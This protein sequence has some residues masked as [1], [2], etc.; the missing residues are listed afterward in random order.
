MNSSEQSITVSGLVANYIS[1][2]K[3]F[4]NLKGRARRSEFWYF[5]LVNLIIS[6]SLDFSIG[7]VLPSVAALISLI[8]NLAI[9][10]PS[11]ALFVRRMHDVEKSGWFTLVPVYNVILAITEGTH[12]PN[13]YGPDPKAQPLVQTAK[14]IA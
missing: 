14:S 11:I 12:G 10:I 6:F 2:L 8:Y 13:Q 5:A 4:S 9:L 1:V 7:L 3:N